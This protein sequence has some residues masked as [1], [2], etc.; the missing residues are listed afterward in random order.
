MRSNI[1]TCRGLRISLSVT[2]TVK[3]AAS[4][5]QLCDLLRILNLGNQM[6]DSVNDRKL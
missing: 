2:K 3:F 5:P 4:L 1:F 6:H